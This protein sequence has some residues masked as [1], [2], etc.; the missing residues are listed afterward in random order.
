MSDARDD[1]SRPAVLDA[2]LRTKL[3][4]P[5]DA[6]T[7]DIRRALMDRIEAGEF[8]TDEQLELAGCL[9]SG[10]PHLTDSEEFAT[11]AQLRRSV[12]EFNS[13]FFSLA[14]EPRRDRL[15][16][17]QK[18]VAGYPALEMRLRH[19]QDALRV[20]ARDVELLNGTTRELADL[21]LELYVLPQPE[22]ASVRRERLQ[23]ILSDDSDNKDSREWRQATFRLLKRCPQVARLDVNLL[24]ALGWSPSGE[25]SNREQPRRSRR[26]ESARPKNSSRV[27]QIRFWGLAALVLFAVVISNVVNN[28]R[29]SSPSPQIPSVPSSPTLER[30]R[31]VPPLGAVDEE[32]PQ[33]V[34]DLWRDLNEGRLPE[35]TAEDL[36]RRFGDDPKTN[37]I[38]ARLKQLIGQDGAVNSI[39]LTVMLPRIIE[40][41][42]EESAVDP[43]LMLEGAV[44]LT[45]QRVPAQSDEVEAT[46]VIGVAPSFR[47]VEPIQFIQAVRLIE[48]QF[49]NSVHQPSL[50][51]M[52]PQREKLLMVLETYDRHVAEGFEAP[53]DVQRIIQRFRAS[54]EATLAETLITNGQTLEARAVIATALRH[55]PEY[56]RLYAS[57]SR[58]HFQKQDYDAAFTDVDRAIHFDPE[59]TRLYF[60]RASMWEQLRDFEQASENYSEIISREPRNF[61]AWKKRG[62]NWIK[63]DPDKALEDLTMS[64]QFND[65][66][67][68]TLVSRGK[69]LSSQ[70]QHDRAI[71][72]LNKAVNQAPES[73][74]A[75]SVRG[76]IWHARRNFDAAYADMSAAI[77]RAPKDIDYRCN[78]AGLLIDDRRYLEAESDLDEAQRLDETYARVHALRGT[79]LSATRRFDASLLAWS[80]AID[81]SPEE[82]AYWSQRAD[83]LEQL[84]RLDDALDDREQ[85]L[86]LAPKDREF[87]RLHALLLEKRGE[88]EFAIEDWNE[89]VR[90]FPDDPYGFERRS[91]CR[92][93]L[94]ARER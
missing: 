6:S 71:A 10:R 84:Q 57:R 8:A 50:A 24:Q 59:N 76:E 60:Q 39:L 21:I 3:E 33:A 61:V 13:E 87:L 32:L 82:P 36:D 23:E 43:L 48:R 14:P 34:R 4:Q 49:A 16:R 29:N 26:R 81:L 73:S 52:E 19:P 56:A 75:L 46:P 78:R 79:L 53:Q 2:W 92:K 40:S 93:Q 94:A 70:G 55:A 20:D 58:L 91:F 45:S 41:L 67:P 51:A 47:Q 89:F 35:L 88:F 12:T 38:K 77:R 63:S 44:A 7:D 68:E 17:L 22:K 86:G 90:L 74:L 11:E 31:Q 30:P 85:A 54:N 25:S 64:L 42:K 28:N 62:L 18:E 65:R 5:E 66:Q 72:D 69:L 83:V 1:N 9:F 80:E 27:P 37:P 15:K